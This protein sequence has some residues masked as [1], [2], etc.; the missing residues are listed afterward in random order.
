MSRHHVCLCMLLMC[1]LLLCVKGQLWREFIHT[2]SHLEYMAFSRA[3]ALA[4]VMWAINKPQFDDFRRPLIP[5]LFHLESIG[6][7]FRRLDG[8][9]IGHDVLTDDEEEPT[10][11]V[12][13]DDDEAAEEKAV[14]GEEGDD[15]AEEEKVAEDVDD[16]EIDAVIQDAPAAA[17]I[18]EEE[19]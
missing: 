12:V 16:G 9:T 7:N 19:A 2:I 18:A 13:E 15:A 3:I 1:M 17:D 5:H 8:T 4:E 14:E 6:V 10:A 11:A